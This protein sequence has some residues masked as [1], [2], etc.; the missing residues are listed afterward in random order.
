MI[1]AVIKV[2]IEKTYLNIK[3]DIYEKPI[4][5]MTLSIGKLNIFI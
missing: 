4:A 5:N 1:K 3:K 2:G